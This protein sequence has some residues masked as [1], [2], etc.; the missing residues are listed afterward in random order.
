M[1]T[2]TPL[3]GGSYN[4]P[5]GSM[6]GRRV[7]TQTEEVQWAI[8]TTADQDAWVEIAQAIRGQILKYAEDITL[9]EPEELKDFVA[10]VRDALFL[11]L[12]A[13]TFDQDLELLRGRITH[14]D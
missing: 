5:V 12:N 4:G 11:E 7:R 8:M 6:A 13:Q 10:A 9:M 2:V 1:Y 3:P 14:E